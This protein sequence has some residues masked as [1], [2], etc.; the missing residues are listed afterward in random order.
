M[1]H[2]A[3]NLKLPRGITGFWGADSAPPPHLDEK[4]FR[5]MCY[6]LARASGGQV[7]EV[8]TDALGRNFY[9]AKLCRYDASVFFLQN[10]HAPYGAFARPDAFGGF[11]PVVQ[12]AW[13]R[14]PEGFSCILSP[15]V[16]ARDWHG[17]CGALSPEEL[18]QIHSWKPSTVGEIL[19]HHWD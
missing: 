1:N 13:L 5:Q 9:A 12:P 4:A 3:D 11:V 6:A 16:L 18:K 2:S 19:F 15:A 10:L 17:L 14:L 8:D 7:A